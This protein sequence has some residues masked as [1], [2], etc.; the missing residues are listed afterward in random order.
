MHC[1]TD[2]ERAVKPFTP[3][4][5][6]DDTMLKGNEELNKNFPLISI[7]TPSLNQGAYIES[8]IKSVLNQGYP[9]F[10]HIIIDGG[11]TDDTIEILEKYHHL[12]W[13]SEKDSGQS[14]A[15]N[16][17]FRRTKGNI[18]GWLNSDDCYEP[19][20]FFT[21]VKELSRPQG[22]YVIFGDCNVIDEKGERIGYCKGRFPDPDNLMKYW[23][24]DYTIPQ[25]SVF[26]Y[27][28]VFQDIGYLDEGL[29][30]AMDY[31]YWLRISKHYQFHYV[32][33]PI[34]VMRIHDRAK[35]IPGDKVFER[36]W[37]RV[38]RKYWGSP[39]S[40]SRYKSLFMALNFRSNLMRINA[41]SMMEKHSLKEFRKKIT[42]SIVSNPV[43]LFR[44]KLFSAILRGIL[45]HHYIEQIKRFL[46]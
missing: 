19:D 39:F 9:N 20:V 17:G 14:E 8:N 22:K 10:E 29:H 24:R 11:S 4:G 28:D 43:N 40:I 25:P 6:W 45:G 42:M 31:D 2:D 44:R 27:R 16:K 33:K 23:G 1:F 26:F 30:Y 36:E 21:V 5:Q 37:F 34:A 38:S 3:R 12:I 35:S 13:I 15:I 41:Y 32:S 7:V 46:P 18:I